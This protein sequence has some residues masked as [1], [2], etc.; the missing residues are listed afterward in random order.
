MT[1]DLSC[2]QLDW[3]T[4]KLKGKQDRISYLHNKAR[5]HVANSIREKLLNLGW[6]PVAPPP[7]SVDLSPPDFHLFGCL[8]NHLREKKFNDENDVKIDF[9][10]LFVEKSKDLY[11][12]GI[13]SLAERWRRVIDN[14]GAYR[15]ESSFDCSN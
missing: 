6:I 7:Y 15:T 1:A 5:A 12:G 3:V 2:Q 4:E 8:C 10:N 11:E 9:I 14:D 13:L